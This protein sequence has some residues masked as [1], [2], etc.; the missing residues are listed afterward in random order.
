[1]RTKI[2]TILAALFLCAL[3]SPV[4]FGQKK[5]S[6]SSYPKLLSVREQLDTREGWLK[7]RLD[8][9]LLPM[10]R[11]AK[12]QMWIVT[13]EEF[14]PEPV[15]EF[16]APPIPYEGRRD[17]FIFTDRGSDKL[18]RIAVVR[19]PDELLKKFY[20]VI[21]PP[22]RDTAAT[23]KKIVEERNP[24]TIALNMGGTRGATNGLTYDAYKFLAETLS[25]DYS[26][27]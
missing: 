8:T 27:R 22:G 9:M 6:V 16:I 14:H 15:V 19:Y 10:M 20:E 23:L 1:M 4:A 21:N 18:E 7:T 17:F 3:S 2:I 24:K 13:N 5:T 12:I 26:D 25:K 11:R